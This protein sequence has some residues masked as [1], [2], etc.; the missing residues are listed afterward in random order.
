M[1]KII[2]IVLE[3]LSDRPIGDFGN[4]TPLESAVTF[5]L[6]NLARRGMSGLSYV[7]AKGI[8]PESDIAVISLLGYDVY[9]YYTGR[10]PLES[11][12]EGL[13]INDGDVAFRANFATVNDSGLI[14]DRRVARDLSTE[15]AA[16]LTKEINSK[17][18]L[19]GATFEFKNTVGHRGVLVF[20]GMRSKL[21]G[22]VNN[23]DPAY[24]RNGVMGIARERFDNYVI[25]SSPMP[26]YED[27]LE[28]KE[29]AQIL[30]EFTR[31]AVKV[32][33]DSQVNKKRIKENRI[34]AN[35]ILCRDGGDRLPRFPQLREL[36]GLRFGSFV[37]MPIEK[38]IAFLTGMELISI[39]ESTGHLDVDYA[40]WAKIALTS[41]SEYDGIYI[42]IKNIDEVSHDGDFNK[43]KEIVEYIDKFF[44]ANI[45]SGLN[46]SDTIIAVTSAHSTVCTLKAHSS[47]PSP[48]LIA[49]GSIKPDKVAVF[50]EKA[51]RSGGLGE[52]EA[53][54]IMSYLVRCARGE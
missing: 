35:A 37:K 12:A 53:T 21:S 38:G 13:I 36:Y 27:S 8:S 16:A 31:K 34:P 2:Y 5:N 43:K 32:L 29:T 52:I 42:H 11:F 46:I 9:K 14:E 45:L 23:T 22:W 49:G 48:F 40:V 50:S 47:D 41:I 44:L 24:G 26:G 4:K 18:T 30:N 19:S 20:R 15:E 7:C 51:A 33:N 54:N 6:D 10:G 3:G 1:K 28:A 25:E 17:I 39:P